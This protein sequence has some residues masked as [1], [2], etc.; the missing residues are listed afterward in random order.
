MVGKIQEQSQEEEEGSVSVVCRERER[1]RGWRG[2]RN[3]REERGIIRLATTTGKKKERK[4]KAIYNFRKKEKKCCVHRKKAETEMSDRLYHMSY[5]GLNDLGGS[6]CQ[7]C[8][9]PL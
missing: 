6:I 9:L 1:E 3:K 8:F 7:Q 2:E 4:E 5:Y